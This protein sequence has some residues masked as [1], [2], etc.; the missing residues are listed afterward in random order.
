[1]VHCFRSATATL[2]AAALGLAAAGCSR[3][4]A[5]EFLDSSL[6]SCVPADTVFLAGVD[7][8]RLRAAP[9]Y[10]ALAP[11]PV[12]AFATASSLALASNGKTY[13][14]VQRGKFTETPDG[15]TLIDS[16]LALAGAPDAVRAGIAQ[17]LSGKCGVPE[18][19]AA[20]SAAAHGS[21]IWA[22]ARGNAALPLAGNLANLNRLFRFTDYVTFAATLDGQVELNLSGQCPSA[23]A[24]RRFEETLRALLSLAAA[25]NARQTDVASL[26]GSVQVRRD[27]LAVHATVRADAAAAGKVAGGILR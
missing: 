9:A 20:A 17:H 24:A 16:S 7:L 12:G 11:S 21:Q 26:L 8:D 13:L 14:L 1:M 15:A 25:A 22:I 10:R 27:G 18:L 6:A 19:L 5:P 23:E 3:T 2:A 4:T